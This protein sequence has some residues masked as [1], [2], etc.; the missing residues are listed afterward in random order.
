MKKYVFYKA[1]D[2]DT[3]NLEDHG[4]MPL[5]MDIDGKTF[6]TISLFTKQQESK[7]T[8]EETWEQIRKHW[9]NKQE[10]DDTMPTANEIWEGIRAR[11]KR[12]HPDLT[13]AV[14]VSRLLEE[15]P[16]LYDRYLEAIPSE[17][18]EPTPS[19]EPQREDEEMFQK[20]IEAIQK[21]HPTTSKAQAMDEFLRTPEGG[22][23]YN[24][25][26]AARGH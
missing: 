22:R 26:L 18:S 5:A 9:F 7:W 12:K 8:R 20:Q 2:G 24:E 14:A 17:G 3:I 1:D 13:E 16:E 4:N 25:Y 15:E 6:R 11:A 10:G 21:A 19:E 23:F